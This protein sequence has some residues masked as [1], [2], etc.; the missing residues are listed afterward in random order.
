MRWWAVVVLCCAAVGSCSR[1]DEIDT[2]PWQAAEVLPNGHVALTYPSNEYRSDSCWTAEP[3]VVYSEDTV[4]I[5]LK[6][7]RMSELCTAEGVDPATVV[8][9]LAEPVGGRTIVAP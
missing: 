4:A 7:R 6:F 3:E 5:E 1:G 8:V 2:V 9:E